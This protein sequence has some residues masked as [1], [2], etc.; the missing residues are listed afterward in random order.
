MS[1]LLNG[2]VDTR[3][4]EIEQL[5]GE[6]ER[7]Q[8]ELEVARMAAKNAEKQASRAV[9]ALRQQLTPLYRGLQL[10]FGEMDKFV[11]E[12]NSPAENGSK[13]DSIKAR[14]APR[15]REAIDLL[16]L[17]GQMKRT[18]LA[19]ALKMDYSNCTKNVVGVL[20]SQGWIVESGGNISLKQ[21]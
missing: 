19:S 17:Q 1:L 20:K 7:L 15:L 6:V 4:E 3:N 14:L 8:D 5:R 12:S 21:I 16:Q 10:L 11:P 2:E 18:Q 13:W 9:A